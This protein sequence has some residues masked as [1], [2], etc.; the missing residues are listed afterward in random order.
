MTAAPDFHRA[1]SRDVAALCYDTGLP[2]W[3]REGLGLPAC[4]GLSRAWNQW[5][6]ELEPHWIMPRYS[7]GVR[8]AD[9]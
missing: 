6:C 7:Y 4:C 8:G 9:A 1:F 5:S 2:D 3:W